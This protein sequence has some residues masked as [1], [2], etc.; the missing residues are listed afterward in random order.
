MI[1]KTIDV[2]VLL[3]FFLLATTILYL[4]GQSVG[5]DFTTFRIS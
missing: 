3:L 4:I 1:D 2:L 5:H